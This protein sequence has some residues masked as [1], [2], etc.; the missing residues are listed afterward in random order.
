MGSYYGSLFHEVLFPLYETGLR[1]RGTI[2]YIDE[3]D[4]GQ[5]LDAEDID[6]LRWNKLQRLLRHCW[7]T[8]PYYRDQWR[9]LGIESVEDIRGY[10]DFARL[11]VLT[12][13]HIREN[14]SRLQSRLVSREVMYKSTGGSTGEALRFGYTRESYERRT[15]VMWRGY[16]W[17]GLTPGQRALYLW[18]GALGGVSRATRLKDRVYHALFNRRMLD[19]FAMTEA[20]LADYAAAIRKFEPM[21]IVSYVTPIVRLARWIEQMGRPISGV[22][23]VIGAAEALHDFQRPLIEAAFPGAQVFNTYGCREFMLIASECEHHDGL[24]V[25]ADHLHVELLGTDPA[26]PA[27]LAITDLSNFGMPF[28]RYLN[29]DLALAHAGGACACGRTLPRLAKVVGRKLDMIRSVDGRLLP[30]EFFPH[31]F[32]DVAG[33]RRFQVIQSQLDRLL[34]KVVAEAAFD[35]K[36]ERYVRE[37]ISRVLGDAVFVDL[38]RVDRIPMTPS[39][40]H[41]VTISEVQ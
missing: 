33:V 8:V 26:V 38:Q 13:E 23:S 24:H 39:G 10:A 5:W 27:E 32:K 16:G 21:V 4:R 18:G 29:G 40:K 31:M 37:Q 19:C 35:E 1:R 12:K 6:A 41:R 36:Q 3:Y 30:G 11:P 17:A 7:E 25:N 9:G 22:R 14:F 20:N 2:R 34:V 28:L 15:A